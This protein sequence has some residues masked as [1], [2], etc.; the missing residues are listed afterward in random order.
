MTH[1]V[2][3]SLIQQPETVREEH[4]Y[5]LREITDQYPYFVQARV[6][7]LKALH[8]SK[9]IRFEV[10]LKLGATYSAN[11]RKLYY[12]IFP[13]QKLATEPYRRES[14]GKSS[15]DYFELIERIE[16]Q[17]SD[18]RQSLQLL[19]ERL[20]SARTMV[21]GTQ[22]PTPAKL[23]SIIPDTPIKV[24][25]EIIDEIKS[26][27]IKVVVLNNE[28]DKDE[29]DVK[30]LIKQ[31][32]YREAIEILKALNLNNPKKSVYFA[33]QIRFL[34]KVISITKK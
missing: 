16:R 17:G 6:L 5:D 31:H 14:S 29:S 20:K 32:K 23:V 8:L 7:L 27:D 1:D 18:T 12:Y 13:E 15:G 4:L 2:F 19:A 34:E 28:K 9:N 33:D 10:D 3:I 30:I 22:Q 21:I 25:S 11:R 24:D 26:P